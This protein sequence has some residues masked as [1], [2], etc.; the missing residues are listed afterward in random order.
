MQNEIPTL[1]VLLNGKRKSGKDFLAE[2]LNKRYR[3]EMIV[4]G[5]RMRAVDNGYFCRLALEMAGADRYPVWI[6]SDTRRR[7]D[8]SWFR[9]KYGDRVK[10]IQ[11]K[12]NLTTRELRGFVFTK[13]VDDAESE[14]DLDGVTGWDLT[15]VNNGDPRPLD[16]AVDTVTAWCTPGRSA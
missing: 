10:T 13:G 12:A 6:V 1:I 16:E 3:Q 7:T 9:E 5:E 2:L 8:I 14:C 11:V 4:W 15:V